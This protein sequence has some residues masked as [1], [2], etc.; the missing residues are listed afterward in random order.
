MIKMSKIPATVRNS[1]WN[2]YIGGGDGLC[3]CCNSERITRGN[4]ECGHVV[5][6]KGGG[7]SS[8]ANLRPICALCNRSMGTT[9]MERFM[10]TYGYEKSDF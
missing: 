7:K 2:K 10:K 3:L 5:S 1:V 4:F 9:N 8:V 6:R